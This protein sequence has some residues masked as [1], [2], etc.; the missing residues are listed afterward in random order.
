MGSV[1]Q[2]RKAPRV[3]LLSSSKPSRENTHVQQPSRS[4]TAA[5]RTPWRIKAIY[6][7]ATSSGGERP[8]ACHMHMSVQLAGRK[9]HAS[10]SLQN[11][12]RPR[13]SSR[14]RGGAVKEVELGFSV[15]Q[16]EHWTAGTEKAA[17]VT[18]NGR[19]RLR[20]NGVHIRF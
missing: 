12:A 11:N 9:T 8:E 17:A 5:V 18:E 7:Q 4:R 14:S 15:Q 20:E 19:L 16:R 10:S 13:T 1:Q 3:H 6:V 2:A